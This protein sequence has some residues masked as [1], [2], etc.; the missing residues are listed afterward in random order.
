MNETLPKLTTPEP[1]TATETIESIQKKITEITDQNS[2]EASQLYFKLHLQCLAAG[3]PEQAIAALSNITDPSLLTMK[4]TLI[5]QIYTEHN[6]L[7]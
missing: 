5:Q 2:L 7:Q 1:L 4:W 6:I 3:K